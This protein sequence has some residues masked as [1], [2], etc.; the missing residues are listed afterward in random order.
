MA[1]QTTIAALCR[2]AKRRGQRSDEK[3]RVN[4]AAKG[5]MR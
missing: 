2:A 3:R 4:G 5:G 1:R